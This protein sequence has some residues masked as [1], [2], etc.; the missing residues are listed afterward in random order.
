MKWCRT[1]SPG[2]DLRDV[3]VARGRSPVEGSA[4]AAPAPAPQ[5]EAEAFQRGVAE[6]E[7]RLREQL[8]KQ[9]AE[10]LQ[11][12]NG[13]LASLRQASSDVVR[14]GESALVEIALETARKLVAGLPISA[15]MVA[16]TV[17]S[18]LA[19]VEEATEFDIYLNAEDLALLQ[20]CNAPDLLPGSD[21]GTLR[22]HG[23]TEVTRGGCLVQT[24]FGVIDAR[25]ETKMELIRQSLGA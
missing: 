10:L 9:R 17:R 6:G 23:S 24:R 15:D 20:A 1:I 12:Q 19:Q 14:Q 8:L 22:F 21:K 25:R 4:A 2:R 13:V 16:A 5:L 11:L 7:K 3:R 18:A